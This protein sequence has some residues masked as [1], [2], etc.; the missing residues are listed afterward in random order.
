MSS[1]E[2]SQSMD[3]IRSFTDKIDSLIVGVQDISEKQVFEAQNM[4]YSMNLAISNI[5]SNL[6]KKLDLLEQVKA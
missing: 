3:I 4:L 2:I 6:E 1:L 5:N